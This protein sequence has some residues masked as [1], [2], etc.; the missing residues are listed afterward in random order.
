[1]KLVWASSGDEIEIVPANQE[2]CEYYVHAIAPYNCFR[3]TESSIDTTKIDYLKSALD[4]INTFLTRYKIAPVFPVGD[5][6]D[7]KWLNELHRSWVKFHIATPKIIQLLK[8][9][10]SDLINCFRE[11]NK[12]LHRIER[13]FVQVWASR[14]N[15]AVHKVSNPFSN[16][17]SHDMANLQIV[18]HD[19]GRTT[20]NKWLHFDNDL[21]AVDTNDYIN[22]PVEVELNLNRPMSFQPPAEYISWCKSNG[23]EQIPGR[24]LNLGNI[25]DLEDRLTDYRHLLIRNKNIDML[26]TI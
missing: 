5:P 4:D 24:W 1:M 13:M 9:R 17:L 6:L 23:L 25:K 26:L 18:F 20:F 11:I 8:S 19:L 16:A 10:E 14:E 7:Q 22:M 21:D 3:C 2:L 15:G 12:T